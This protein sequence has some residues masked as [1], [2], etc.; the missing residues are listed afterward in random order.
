[1]EKWA[2]SQVEKGTGPMA[3]VLRRAKVILAVIQHFLVPQT[4]QV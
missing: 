4:I 2:S 3:E 1:M